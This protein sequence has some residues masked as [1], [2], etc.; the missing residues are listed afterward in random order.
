MCEFVCVCDMS[1][2]SVIVCVCVIRVW[3]VCDVSVMCVT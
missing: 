3:C 1:D 2:M